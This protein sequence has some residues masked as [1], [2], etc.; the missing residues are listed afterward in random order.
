MLVFLHWPVNQ[1]WRAR[2]LCAPGRPTT[3]I[4]LYVIFFW[5]FLQCWAQFR[6][7]CRD[8]LFIKSYTSGTA[9][10][11]QF[12]CCIGSSCIAAF[13]VFGRPECNSFP[14][15]KLSVV[16]LVLCRHSAKKTALLLRRFGIEAPPTEPNSSDAIFLASKRWLSWC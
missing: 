11:K 7:T 5:H 10:K 13:H 12:K 15:S 1:N 8:E 3:F 6:I 16:L 2:S 14:M 9:G 4:Y